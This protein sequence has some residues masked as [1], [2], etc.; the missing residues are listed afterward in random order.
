[1]KYV[2]EYRDSRFIDTIAEKI[3]QT[4]TRN[5]NLMEICGGQTHSILKYNLTSFLPEKIN[6]IHGPGCPVC[7]TPAEKIDLA[8]ELA[9]TPGVILAS[10]GDMLRVPGTHKDLLR[11]RAEGGDVRIVYSPLDCVK[12]SL[13]NP[14]K[15]VVFFAIGFETTASINALLLQAAHAKKL[16]NLS[17]LC[18]QVLVPPAIEFILSSPG[19]IIQGFLAAGHVCTVTGFNEYIPVARK[20]KVPMAITGFEPLDILLGIYAVVA[21]LEAGTSEV[22]NE[23]KRSVTQD[24]NLAAQKSIAEVFEVAD[25]QW[26]GIGTIAQSGL[27]IREKYKIFDAEKRFS[28]SIPS[29]PKTTNCVSGEILQGKI[30]PYQCPSFGNLCTPEHPLGAPMVSH[31][32]ACSAYYHYKTN[33]YGNELS[34]SYTKP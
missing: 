19:N 6:L 33:N 3:R 18:S 22:T 24:G 1:M 30:K 34:H 15:E 9:Q 25:Q 12:L 10:F 16:E 2:D 14:D 23:Y 7:V 21:Q 13:E 11:A 4:V 31:E 27:I 32:G 8:V 29:L 26:R 17:L 5:W 20:H 28:L